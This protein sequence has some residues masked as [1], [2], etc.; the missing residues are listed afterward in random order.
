DLDTRGAVLVLETEGLL[1]CMAA[2]RLPPELRADLATIPLDDRGS[3]AAAA[4]VGPVRVLVEDL[5]SD[6]RWTTCREAQLAAGVRGCWAEPIL[7]STGEVLGVLLLHHLGDCMPADDAR[8]VV[9]AAAHLAGI[10]I[11]RKRAEHELAKA[12]DVAVTAARL[13]SE[14]LA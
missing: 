9:E 3:C 14:F 1:R 2:P 7:G 5:A 11:E 12:R 6:R 4:A 13:K 8:G 10:A